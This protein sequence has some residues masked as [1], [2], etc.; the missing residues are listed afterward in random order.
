MAQEQPQMRTFQIQ[1]P[2]ELA[3]C[4]PATVLAVRTQ[5]FAGTWI[6]I[7]AALRGIPNLDN[8]IIGVDHVDKAGIVWGIEGRP[9]G[10]GDRDCADYFRGT[11]AK[12]VVS[13]WR[14]PLTPLQRAGI[15]ATMR[16]LKGTGY[17]WNEII[18]DGAMDLHLPGIAE[19]FTRDEDWSKRVPMHLVCSTTMAYAYYA[20]K[21]PSP[22]D[23]VIA[24]VQGGVIKSMPLIQPGDWT[25]WSLENGYN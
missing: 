3:R 4:Q 10:V 20:N 5:G 1:G 23:K 15:T 25:A 6:R 8:H 13:N 24:G 17:D 19:L 22:A 9:G 18:G 14:Q 2:P 7:G 16:K 21:A 11:D 12:Y